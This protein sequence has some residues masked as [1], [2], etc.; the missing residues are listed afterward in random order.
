MKILVSGASGL[1][2]SALMKEL[3]THDHSV[4]ALSRRD[5][6]TNYE[7][8]RWNP[9]AEELDLEALEGFD[10]VV[11]LAGRN[12]AARWSANVKREIVESR[13]LGTEFL[14]RSL[15]ELKSPP[16][17]IIFASA[18]GYYGNRGEEILDEESSMGDG[19]L[20]V[21]CRDWESACHPLEES[22]KTA[23]IRKVHVRIGVVLSKDGGA[24]RKML[25]P[26]KLGVGGVVGSGK[27]YWSWIGIG[28]LVRVFRFCLEN[29]ISGI[30]NA[31]APNP[32]TN[33]EFTKTLGKVLRRPTIFPLPAFAARIALGEMA[34]ELL[35]A[36]ARVLPKRLLEKS[37]EFAHGQLEE[38]LLD[39]L[40]R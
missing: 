28:D 20:A 6:V 23:S 2:G 11:H 26:F 21:L 19:F 31:T 33:K 39:V 36:S 29:E 17:C 22:R 38:A 12:I 10:A 15:A 18:I 30:V 16:Q 4:T 1:V 14:C 5:L 8:I 27:Q 37:F 9:A 3:Q 13:V 24:L 40:K 7:R 25:L 35:L 34:N 32:V